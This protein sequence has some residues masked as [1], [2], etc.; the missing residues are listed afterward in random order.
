M[1]VVRA[2]VAALGGRM[3]VH[4]RS[5]QGVLFTLYLPL[6]LAVQQVCL[7]QHGRQQYAIP[8]TLIDSVLQLRSEQAR[9]ALEQRAL[10]VDGRPLALYPLHDLLGEPRSRVSRAGRPTRP[11][12]NPPS[13][14]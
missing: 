13:P 8:S 4:S 11:P 1:D 14:C 6:S 10:E 5:G 2:E 7:L 9:Q 12:P 3:T